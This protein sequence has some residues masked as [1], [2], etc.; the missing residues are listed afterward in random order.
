MGESRG[1][2]GGRG[3]DKSKKRLPVT[4]KLLRVKTWDT[5]EKRRERRRITRVQGGMKGE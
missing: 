2:V 3:G 4:A 5:S 1:W